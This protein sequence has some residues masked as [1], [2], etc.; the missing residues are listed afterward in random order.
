[1]IDYD[2]PHVVLLVF[3]K[4][5]HMP[6]STSLTAK[7]RDGMPSDI[8]VFEY[9]AEAYDQPQNRALIVSLSQLFDRM[10]NNLTVYGAQ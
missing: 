9:Q 6:E 2:T 5:S 8:S 4:I 1:M 10:W 3:K 7:R